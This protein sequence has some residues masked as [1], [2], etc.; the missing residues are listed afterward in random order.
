ML[1]ILIIGDAVIM[2]IIS[3]LIHKIS[4]FGTLP[5]YLKFKK[6]TCSVEKTQRAILKD[7]LELSEKT[8]FGK[9]HSLN[10]DMSYETFRARVPLSTYPD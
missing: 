3:R 7:L 2:L 9:K 6:A 1:Y 4:Q 8:V 10:A 5:G